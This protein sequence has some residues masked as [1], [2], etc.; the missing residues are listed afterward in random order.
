[1]GQVSDPDFRDGLQ[2]Q[3]RTTELTANGILNHE[4]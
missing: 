2:Y 3:G 4:R 1:M